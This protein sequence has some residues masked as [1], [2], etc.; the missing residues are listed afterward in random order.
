MDTGKVINVLFLGQTNSS[1]SLIAE[2]VLNRHGMG[3]FK[4]FSAAQDPR[5]EADPLVMEELRRQNYDVSELKPKSCEAF[6]HEGADALQ[7]VF[8]LDENLDDQ[9]AWP[10]HPMVAHWAVDDPED[11]EGSEPSKRWMIRR[12]IRELENRI[13]IF[14]S[15]PIDSLDRLSLQSHLD[16][17]GRSRT[18]EE[19]EAVG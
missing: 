1:D 10:G 4:A 2:C 7:F 16:T 15:L 18:K 14:V 12:V 9:P 13:K 11:F 6:Q 5:A 19:E 17:I 3:K 8:T